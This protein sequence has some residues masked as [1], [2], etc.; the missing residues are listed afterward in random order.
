MT[1]LH[2]RWAVSC[3]T[4]AISSR[5]VAVDPLTRTVQSEGKIGEIWVQSPSVGSGYWNN[6]ELSAKTFENYLAEDEPSPGLTPPG[7]PVNRG[8]HS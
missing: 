7:S 4:A 8:G 6:P 5:V 1:V 3:G 2:E